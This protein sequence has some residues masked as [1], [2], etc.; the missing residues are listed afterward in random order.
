M[1]LDHTA[2]AFGF[3]GWSILPHEMNLIF[4]NIGRISFPIFSF[5]LVNGWNNTSNKEKYFNKI[6]I[7]SIIS[8]I[9]Y[10]LAFSIANTQTIANIENIFYIGLN[11]SRFFIAVFFIIMMFCYYHILKKCRTSKTPYLLLILFIINIISLKINYI[12]LL[13]D[14]L[15]VLNTF[16]CALLMVKIYENF[17]NFKSK[18]V[19][20]KYVYFIINSF[21]FVLLFSFNS[22][23]GNYLMG[24]V[25]I[26]L[27]YFTYNKKILSS[28]VIIFWS[29]M[30]YGLLFSNYQYFIF[31]SISVFIIIFYN[32]EKV[33]YLKTIFYLMYP[34]HLFIIGII[35]ILFKS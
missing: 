15:N 1:I 5:A 13:T 18:K 11:Y 19:N 4:R 33:P 31:S 24:I 7:F 2:A 9:P 28:I 25:L 14:S 23:Y 35:N 12:W 16:I 6:V 29:F 34:F 32:K 30:C 20:D 21:I 3:T 22:D 26:M 27:L 8:Q 17:K 10:S